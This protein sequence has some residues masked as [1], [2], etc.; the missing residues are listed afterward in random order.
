[1]E[2]ELKS[3]NLA[4]LRLL[5][6]IYTK[7]DVW[8][9][10]TQMASI[11]GRQHK[12][13][14]KDIRKD[15]IEGIVKLKKDLDVFDKK[16]VYGKYERY[17]ETLNEKDWKVIDSMLEKHPEFMAQVFIAGDK[18]N[19]NCQPKI[20]MDDRF[21]LIDSINKLKLIER[22][23]KDAQGRSYIMY[24][25]NDRAALVCLMRYSLAIRLAV[26]DKFL[27]TRNKLLID[28]KTSA[29]NEADQNFQK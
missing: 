19:I 10:S 12:N 13:V 4:Q 11:S 9:S 6:L 1:M 8:I 23:Y 22:T 2:Q 15:M 29:P 28:K 21:I 24:L 18:Q 14:L 17:L 7:D 3:Y 16:I 27:D 5:E 20:E 26:V 25:L